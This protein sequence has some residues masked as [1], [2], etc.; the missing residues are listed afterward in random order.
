MS[1][2][3][4][5]LD[6]DG[7]NT[8]TFSN[9]RDFSFPGN[10]YSSSEGAVAG[11]FLASASCS[12]GSPVSNIDVGP[13]ETRARSV[14]EPTVRQDHVAKD[15]RPDDPQDFD[16]TAGG[17][18]SPSTFQLDDDGAE[19]NPRSSHAGVHQRAAWVRLLGLRVGAI[20]LDPGK[21]DVLRW[22]ADHEHRRFRGE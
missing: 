1:P 19:A 5:L 17:G 4:F 2:A 6:D 22:L 15:A 21:R 12:D 13:A 18:L 8:N 11:W 3:N 7:I 20:G 9:T 10:G 14:R 16:F